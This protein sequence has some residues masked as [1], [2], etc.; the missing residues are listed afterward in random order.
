MLQ[1]IGNYTAEFF[2]EL[3]TN[4]LIGLIAISKPVVELILPAIWIYAIVLYYSTKEKSSFKTGIKTLYIYFVLLIL[5]RI[6]V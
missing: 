1:E 3:F 6:L 5:W 4:M 2:V